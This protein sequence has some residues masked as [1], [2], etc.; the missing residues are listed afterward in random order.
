MVGLAIP[1]S[2]NSAVLKQRWPAGTYCC[3]DGGFIATSTCPPFSFSAKHLGTLQRNTGD[4]AI[5]TYRLDSRRAMVDDF[6][7]EGSR[8][9][10]GRVLA[11]NDGPV[12]GVALGWCLSQSEWP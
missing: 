6:L 4:S 9:E 7:K 12:L 5:A 3:I 2:D 8:L 11:Q 10:P 1:V